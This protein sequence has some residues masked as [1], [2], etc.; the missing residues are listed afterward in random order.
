MSAQEDLLKKELEKK[1]EEDK[2]K[3][4]EQ[5]DDPSSHHR[6]RRHHHHHHSSGKSRKRRSKRK[7]KK[8]V[9][10][11]V[12]ITVSAILS[13]VLIAAAIVF[14][15]Y[16]RGKDSM[17]QNNG[18]IK[19]PQSLGV[20]QSGD[21]IYYKNGKYK[22]NRD[23]ASILFLGVDKYVST[24][25]DKENGENHQSD[26]IALCAIDSANKKVT[27]INV[28]RDIMTD[29]SVYS[30]GGG[31]VG[32]ERMQIA[33]A[34]AYGDGKKT[35][36]INSSEAVA[37]LFYNIPIN[38]YFSMNLDG[39]QEINDSIGGV[40]VVSPETIGNF[41]KGKEYYLKGWDSRQFIYLRDKSKLNSNLLRNERQKV[42]LNAFIKKFI[43]ATKKDVSTAV[44]LFRASS[45]YSCT[46]LDADKI[47][48]LAT[49]FVVNRNMEY[50]ILSVPVEVKQEG[51]EAQ[52]IVKE[53]EFFE[54]FLKIFYN[55]VE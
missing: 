19:I 14:S 39:V 1:M 42:Y 24:E 25:E 33:L 30:P 26:V 8:R 35:S 50:N 22:Y 29:V 13:L 32:R 52:N 18:Q 2:E 3:E 4:S 38:T 40:S 17:K 27:I 55:K 51:K 44:K 12:I 45:P 23:V 16:I 20:E 53:E 37:R 7:T 43:S 31:Y 34:Y 48:Y 5:N 49:E 54:S 36:C 46:N 41:E 9:K 15:M 21:Y 11:I 28:P 47:T 10:R 6:R